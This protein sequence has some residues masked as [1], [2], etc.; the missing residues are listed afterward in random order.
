[1]AEHLVLVGTYAV[2]QNPVLLHNLKAA[3]EG[4]YLTSLA[5]RPFM[6]LPYPVAQNQ[7]SDQTCNTAG[8]Q[9]GGGVTNSSGHD[10]QHDAAEQSGLWR[11]GKGRQQ[12]GGYEADQNLPRIG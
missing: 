2:R 8:R 4:S 5:G 7:F 10:V 12:P 11:Y 3:P 1:M 6:R 9:P